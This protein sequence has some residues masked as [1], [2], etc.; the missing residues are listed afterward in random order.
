[1]NYDDCLAFIDYILAPKKSDKEIVE[2]FKI[3]DRN[4]VGHIS[5]T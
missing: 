3:F 1:M 2:A 4:G 5:T